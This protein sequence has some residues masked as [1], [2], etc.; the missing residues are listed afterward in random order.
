MNKPILALASALILATSIVYATCGPANNPL[1]GQCILTKSGSNCYQSTYI[2]GTCKGTGTG[3]CHSAPAQEPVMNCALIETGV[4]S[5]TAANPPVYYSI[6]L[7]TDD[8]GNC[9]L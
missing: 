1:G 7:A 8:P 6:P 4:C 3:E 2:A 9:G 5:G